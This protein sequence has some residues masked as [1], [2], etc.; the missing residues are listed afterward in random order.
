M[1][2][3]YLFVNVLLVI[4]N[5]VLQLVKQDVLMTVQ[6][7]FGYLILMDIAIVIKILDFMKQLLQPV[8]AKQ[9]DHIILLLIFANV[10]LIII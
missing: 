9:I 5:S 8:Y 2:M 4:I 10:N 6:H 1:E 3:Q 7:H